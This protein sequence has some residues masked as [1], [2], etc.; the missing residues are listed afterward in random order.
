METDH[1]RG[2][3]LVMDSMVYEVS[4]NTL[5][6][7][8]T[9][10]PIDSRACSGEIMVTYLVEE[11]HGPVRY[12]FPAAIT[13]YI[14]D[15][16]TV[17]G[18]QVQALLI[19]RKADTASYSIRTC[20][21]VEPTPMSRLD[22]YVHDK[23]ATIV[24]ISLGGVRFGYDRS[25]PLEAGVPVKLRFD[26][27]G[28]EYTVDA[29]ILRISCH[30]GKLRFAVAEFTKAMG[31]FEQAL[32]RRIYAIERASHRQKGLADEEKGDG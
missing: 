24:D 2:D 19:T 11:K 25:I 23:K 5:V 30:K 29:T 4:G 21:R 20:Y 26:V 31:P 18:R 12:G 6:L 13:A 15:Y 16:Q 22:L 1:R 17:R 32:A 3:I 7:A 8:Q 28:E 27:A 10:P 9:A 14:D